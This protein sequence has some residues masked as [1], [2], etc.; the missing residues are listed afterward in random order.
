M[1]G[2]LIKKY[3]ESQLIVGLVLRYSLHMR[4][5]RRILDAGTL[6]TI[7]SLEANE[8]IA[9]FHGSFF[10]RDWRR[11]EKYSGGFMLEKCC[12]DIDLYNTQIQQNRFFDMYSML[13]VYG[14]W[15]LGNKNEQ[16][17][18]WLSPV[19]SIY[20]KIAAVENLLDTLS[21]DIDG[22]GVSDFFDVDDS[23]EAG[24]MVYGNGAPV[25]SDGDGIP[26][27]LDRDKFTPDGVATDE[28]GVA[29]DSDGDGIPDGIDLDPN[30]PLNALIDAKGRRI[31]S[32]CNCDDVMFPGLYF[33]NGSCT[34]RPEYEMA[35][36]IILD[37]LKQCP[38]QKLIICPEA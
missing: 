34:I 21:S 27:H 5:M 6:G 16:H 12:H 11:L 1:G 22:D 29:I 36:A 7:T 3:G 20:D 32:C 26:D 24:V 15:K 8:H 14:A 28:F 18:D 31:K 33:A 17:Y 38:N 9:P 35:I 23:T 4:E 25:D 10:M 2:I 13:N 30:S 37:K 19:E